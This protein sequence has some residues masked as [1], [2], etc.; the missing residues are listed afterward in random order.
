LLCRCGIVQSW[1]Q[2]NHDGLPQKAGCPQEMVNEIHGSWTD[3]GNPVVKYGGTLHEQAF[4]W[5]KRETV[6]ADLILVLGTSLGG[7]TADMVAIDVAKRSRSGG[8]LGAVCINLQQ[9]PHDKQMALRH[10]GCSDDVLRAFLSELGI[11]GALDHL[12]PTASV[13][14]STVSAE[15]VVDGADRAEGAASAVPPSAPGPVPML[16]PPLL[17]AGVVASAAAALRSPWPA[18][19]RV[20]VPYDKFGMRLSANADPA[21][22]WM[23]W[24]LTPGREVSLT[25]G[26]NIQGAKQPAYLHIGRPDIAPGAVA[27]FGPQ[28]GAVAGPGHSVT[29]AR[30][31]ASLCIKLSIEG[32]SMSLGLW[33]LNAALQGAVPKL[34]IINRHQKFAPTSQRARDG[35]NVQ[36]FT[37]AAAA[38]SVET[39]VN[40]WATT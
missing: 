40:D 12:T 30:C 34:P 23:W 10:F 21:R 19:S 37:A 6:A 7:L 25:A 18:A 2:Q 3:P 36:V 38:E 5:M 14:A 11:L 29:V 9:T 15:H 27:M 28:R 4:P 22:H 16:G 8:A 17:G 35:T 1:I 26:H 20:L 31:K 24:D 32:A 39:E 13:A 33:W